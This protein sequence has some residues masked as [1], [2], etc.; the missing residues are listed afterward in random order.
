[1]VNLLDHRIIFSTPRRLAPISA[2]REHIPFGMFLVDLLRPRTL[3]ELGTHWG[4][5]YCGF[6]QAVD[7]LRLPTKCHA[8][9]TWKGDA[10]S[11]TY[12]PEVLADL[13]AHHDPLYGSFSTLVE[14]T[15]DDAL[16]NFSDGSID[17]LHIDGLH[18]YEVVK[19]DVEAWWPKLSERGVLLLHDVNTRRR[20]YGVWK[21]WE[22]LKTSHQHIDLHH[23]HGLG[24]LAVGGQQP[25]EFRELLD[26]SAEG[27]QSL[28]DL[29]F[30]LG[31]RLRLQLLVKEARRKRLELDKVVEARGEA[32]RAANDR[33]VAAAAEKERELG[34]LREE[35][36]SLRYERDAARSE[37][38][39]A[40][41]ELA[42]LRG[43]W[44]FRMAAK[45]V[46]LR[47]ALNQRL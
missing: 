28:R 44:P 36:N 23:A 29:F 17:L 11:G 40:Q 9:D 18:T 15:F 46:S 10:Q 43:R 16:E 8:I 12:G 30:L 31:Y 20:D 13:R 37:A 32:W 21:L 38:K 4:N 24:V 35:L 5:S 19:H 7:E 27:F 3:V 25:E 22:E 42:H 26:M 47:R 6:C 39:A 45:A 34:Q 33:A 2:W 1:V 41:A 14:S